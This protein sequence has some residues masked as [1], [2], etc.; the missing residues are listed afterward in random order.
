MAIQKDEIAAPCPVDP[1]GAKTD[2][3]IKRHAGIHQRKR[4][5]HR[6]DQRR[7]QHRKRPGSPQERAQGFAHR[8]VAVAHFI[9]EDHAT[10]LHPVSERGSSVGNLGLD[11][12]ARFAQAFDQGF[13]RCGHRVSLPIR[14]AWRNGP[15]PSL[16]SS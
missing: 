5:D 7:G 1:V 11:P 12:V 14:M 16:R 15:V 3:L 10:P 9:F 6:V 2:R 13:H 8:T 4:D